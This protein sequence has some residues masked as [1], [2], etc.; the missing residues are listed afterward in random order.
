MEQ[1]RFF[2]L[3]LAYNVTL[4][5][6]GLLFFQI[7]LSCASNQ[8]SCY[9]YN[10]LFYFSQRITHVTK[11]SIFI[12]IFCI[13]VSCQTVTYTVLPYDSS[14]IPSSLMCC[15]KISR[16]RKC[17]CQVSLILNIKV[18]AITCLIRVRHLRPFF[19]WIVVDCLH[20]KER[21]RG[22]LDSCQLKHL[23]VPPT[24]IGRAMG[25]AL[26]ILPHT[27]T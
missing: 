17:D 20:L 24:T 11:L 10:I 4:L 2:F 27:G 9:D 1:I 5:S 15:H 21:Q 26:H 23:S 8:P 16:T 18:D 14:N 12:R 7:F 6:K 13:S 19:V 3:N 22:V 25:V